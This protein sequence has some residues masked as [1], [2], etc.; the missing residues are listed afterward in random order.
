MSPSLVLYLK[1]NIVNRKLPRE[2]WK[3]AFCAAD[4]KDFVSSFLT[5][6]KNVKGEA[7]E[8]REAGGDD[9]LIKSIC[10]GD[11]KAS[12]RLNRRK[13]FLPPFVL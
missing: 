2:T 10:R 9:V 7:K 6:Y 4:F 12:A 11:I 5:T 1:K 13:F 8:L 3:R